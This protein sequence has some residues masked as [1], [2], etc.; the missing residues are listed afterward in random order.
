MISAA[1]SDSSSAMLLLRTIMADFMC[2]NAFACKF[3]EGF[4]LLMISDIQYSIEN[5]NFYM[6]D[7]EALGD[8][9]LEPVLQL[10]LSSL[11]AKDLL[12]WTE[13]IKIVQ[14]GGESLP[15]H[16]GWMLRLHQWPKISETLNSI[17]MCI[18]IRKCIN[19]KIGNF[20]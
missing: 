18:N 12:N 15:G 11:Q 14:K 17:L 5:T 13:A 7:F 4:W 1:A 2:D 16:R 9:K 8:F 19:A 3:L 20:F 10:Q 6:L